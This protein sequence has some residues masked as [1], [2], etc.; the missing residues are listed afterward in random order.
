MEATPAAP[1]EMS[2][3]DLLLEFLIIPFD[4]PAQLGEVHQGR[5][6]DVFGKGREPVFGRF[7]LTFRPLDQQPLFRPALAAL[8]VAPRNANAHTSKARRQRL[9]GAF[10]PFD[11]APDRLGQAKREFLDRDWLMRGVAPQ[12]LGWPSPT[13]P[14]L[15]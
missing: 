14:L 12:Q 4:A 13:R 9:S 5:E 10:A 15:C 7:L 3:P 2:E 8:E 1:F 6:S 11:G